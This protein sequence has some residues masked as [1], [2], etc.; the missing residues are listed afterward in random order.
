VATRRT[1][2]LA[3]VQA[4]EGLPWWYWTMQRQITD[5]RQDQQNMLSDIAT[6]E[7]AVSRNR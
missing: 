5:L 2:G 7:N 3:Q 1:D 4:E 6:L